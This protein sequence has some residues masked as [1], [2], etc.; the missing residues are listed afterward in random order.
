[1]TFD[2]FD[3]WMR[4]YEQSLDQVILPEIYLVARL[5][6]RGFTRL[7]KEVCKFEAPF[8]VRFKELMVH[9]AQALMDC[10]FRVLYAYTESDEI[11][12]LFAPDETAFGRKIR[13]FNSTLAGEASAAFSLKLGQKATFDCR[14]V[15]L[16]T[17]ERVQDYFRWRQ[18]DAHRNSLN[19]YC[20]WTLR[21]EG[22]TVRQAT[23][24]L[25]GQGV[26]FK[27]E[28]LFNY[29]INYDKLPSWQKRGIGLWKEKYEKEGYNPVTGETVP[30]TRSRIA[31]CEELPLGEAYAEMIRK[32]LT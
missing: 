20:Y 16:P 9:T 23:K 19:S 1:M 24:T 25:E 3:K 12:L 26:S 18:E 17:I 14:M 2:E 30:V 7:T 22:K 13:K 21:K 10:G 4:T 11:S 27:N 32:L 29:G 15:P 5:D 31:V 6:G 28:M 8:D